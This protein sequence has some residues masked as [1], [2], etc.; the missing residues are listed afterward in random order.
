MNKYKLLSVLL[1]YPSNELQEA[2]TTYIVPALK[3]ETPEW[4]IKLMPLIQYLTDTDLIDIQEQYVMTFDRTPTHSLHLFEHLHGENRD[5]GGAML[6]LLQEY[7]QFGYEPTGYELPDYLPLFLEFLSLQSEQHAAELLAEAVHVI[8][9]IG[10]KL[11]ANQSI[12]ASVFELIV[13]LSPV[14]PE[15]LTVSP[16]KDMDEALEMF[17]PNVQGIEPLLSPKN[18]DVQ[19]VKI[20]PSRSTLTKSSGVQS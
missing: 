9:Y 7:Q 4:N 13:S 8:H 16:V 19:I 15:E 10:Q 3:D 18:H 5:R 14:E 2:M 17:G 11:Q 1:S 20:S 12:Y 6:N